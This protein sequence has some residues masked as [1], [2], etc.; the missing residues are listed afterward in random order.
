MYPSFRDVTKQLIDDIKPF[1]QEV[2]A[3]F[4]TLKREPTVRFCHIQWNTGMFYGEWNPPILMIDTRLSLAEAIE[5]LIHEYVHAEQWDRGD[6]S[7]KSGTVYWQK[8][9]RMDQAIAST[10]S[11]IDYR[12]LPWEQEAYE[13]ADAL[14]EEHFAHR[15]K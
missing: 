1:L 12:A 10:T 8:S 3:L 13:R 11:E 2:R 4:P 7:L 14:F 5:T 9:I 6:V 15:I